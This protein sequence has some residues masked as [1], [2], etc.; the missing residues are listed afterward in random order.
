LAVLRVFRYSFAN[1]PKWLRNK[2]GRVA[3]WPGYNYENAGLT[4]PG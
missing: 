2:D 4:W 3:F 1:S